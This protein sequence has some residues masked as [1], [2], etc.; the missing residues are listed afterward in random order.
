MTVVLEHGELRAIVAPEQGCEMRSLTRSGTELLFQAHWPPTPP[1]AA[2]ATAA[3]WEAAWRGGWQLAVPNAGEPC[4]VDGRGHGF[5]G[6]ASVATFEVLGSSA[7]SLGAAWRDPSGLLVARQ[8]ELT[9]A[10]VRARTEVVNTSASRQPLLTMEHL[11]LGGPFAGEDVVI[12]LA[13]GS[14]QP[15]TWDGALDGPAEPWPAGYETLAG[16]PF[17]RFAVVQDL[18]ERRVVLRGGGLRLEL[19]F[20]HP[21]LWLW[22]EA[23]LSTSSPWDGRTACLGVE[24]SYASRADGLMAAIERDEATWLDPAASLTTH[25]ELEIT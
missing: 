25:L 2:P 16:R 19:A 7:S 20:T 8:L 1:P 18:P 10:G 9:S 14:V 4:T 3:A 11:I 21:H 13:G 23:N 5:H 15:Q 17:S 12:E 24:P 6:D 22:Q